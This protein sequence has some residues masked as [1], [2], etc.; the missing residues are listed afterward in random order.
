M[1][2]WPGRL[3]Q[4][5]ACLSPLK[6]LSFS[7]SRVNSSNLLL[8]VEGK[9]FLEL[10]QPTWH[11]SWSAFPGRTVHAYR[12]SPEHHLKRGCSWLEAAPASG[13]VAEHCVLG[14]G[15]DF[16]MLSF[17]APP[18]PCSGDPWQFRR[19]CSSWGP[20]PGGLM[21]MR[22]WVCLALSS[23]ILWAVALFSLL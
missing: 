3:G 17:R 10:L 4:Q 7:P 2:P 19:S 14:W 6:C 13:Q 22:V 8:F 21:G 5:A 16:G 1:C 11:L 9:W 20:E 18:E 23:H 12:T 15:I